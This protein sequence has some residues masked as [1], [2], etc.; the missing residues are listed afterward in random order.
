MIM[1]KQRKVKFFK[2]NTAKDLEERINNFG[3][4]QKIVDISY[5]T[6]DKGLSGLEYSCLVLYEE[7]EKVYERD[8]G[9]SHAYSMEYIPR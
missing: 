1:E 9:S 3:E 7:Y 4:H 8:C 5:S 2:T 6:I